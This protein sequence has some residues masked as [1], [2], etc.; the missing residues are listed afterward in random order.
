MLFG[1][2]DSGMVKEVAQ[3]L[4]F[5]PLALASAA[6]YVKQVRQNKVT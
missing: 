3:A 5:Q 1:V 4:D 2:A 6:T